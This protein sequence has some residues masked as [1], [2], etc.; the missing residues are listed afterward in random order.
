MRDGWV[1]VIHRPGYGESSGL[2]WAIFA[3]K[4]RARQALEGLNSP[5]QGVVDANGRRVRPF[6]YRR[7]GMDRI[8]MD[9]R[10]VDFD[11]R[12]IAYDR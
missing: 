1:W 9:S 6:K 4:R 5:W 2:P 8:A 12:F 11:G 3:D 10:I 7:V